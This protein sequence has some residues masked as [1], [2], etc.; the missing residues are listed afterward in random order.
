[1]SSKSMMPK[2]GLD[3]YSLRSQGWDAIRLL[4]HAASLG[5]QVAH[6]SEPRFLGRL[7]DRY[8][9]QV[10]ARAD[11]LGLEIEVGMGSICPSSTWFHPEEGTAQEQLL[12]MFHV[13][14]RLGSPFVRCY[15][16]SSEDR[17]GP[18]GGPELAPK[19][20]VPIE[21]HIEDTVAVCRSVRSQALD[22]G[23]KIAIENHAGGLSSR[24]LR[25][26]IEE[27]GPEYVGAVYDSGNAAWTLEDPL[28]AL[29]TLA[30]YVLTSH[31]RDSAVWEVP[32]GIAVQWCAMGHGNV[33]IDELPRRF[34]ELCPGKTF[35]LEVINTRS[36]RLFECDK[37]EF[38]E[39]YRDLAAWEFVRFQKIARQGK[40]YAGVAPLP[41]G[42]VEGTPAFDAF[43]VAQERRDVAQAVSYCRT[44]FGLGV[45]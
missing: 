34:A 38:W 29:E 21:K 42:V 12:R 14:K 4:E 30:P 9:D 15:Q 10:K 6:Y 20:P 45:R 32:G 7:D 25:M 37:E 24:L 5:V 27:A 19:S 13:A 43:M 35:S 36:P 23:L 3:L 2:L 44:Q 39:G 41:A 40:P 1:M 8:L 33:G 22:M 17:K 31:I 26:L 28:T 18:A 11:E 16:G